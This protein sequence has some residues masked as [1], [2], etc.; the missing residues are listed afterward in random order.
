M[1]QF[2]V[3][4]LVKGLFCVWFIWSLVFCMVRV[5]GDPTD[6]ML[7]D[8][9]TEA[10]M[11]TLRTALHL[12]EPMA[13][14][15]SDSLTDLLSGNS[16]QSYYYKR[17]V[18]ELYKER[19][20]ATLTLAIPAFTLAILAGIFL[21]TVAAIRHDSLIDRITM[22]G[23]IIGYTLPSFCLGIILIYIFCLK[24]RLLPS[25][26][27]DSLRNLI[28]PMITLAVS[29]LATIARF[30]RSALL[31]VM[32]REYIDG[33]R[34]KGVSELAVTIRHGIRNSLIPVVTGIGMQLGTI[35]GGAVVVETVFSWPG[36]GMLLVTAAKERDF[37]TVQ[38]GILMVAFSV[39]LVN[40][41]IDISY[42]YLDPRIRETFK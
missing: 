29:P 17:D 25:A 28:L 11:M 6:W 9:A 42:G 27:M 7:P 4:R 15:Y 35:I 21:G 3:K 14:Q 40:I 5:T 34:M 16:G 26:G 32:N 2:T 23:A 12:D 10:E 22:S 8:G 37:P 38:Y 20:G 39:N 31:D 1:F 33:A 30:T 36:V 13:K 18:A 24:L 19:M 41:L